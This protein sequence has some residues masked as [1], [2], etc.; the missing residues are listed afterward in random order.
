MH[1]IHPSPLQLGTKEYGW[2]NPFQS[3]T[4]NIFHTFFWCFYCWLWTSKCLSSSKLF[5]TNVKGQDQTLAVFSEKFYDFIL[6]ALQKQPP[7]V[8]WK[9][10][11]IHKK[12]PVLESVFN[13]FT[14]L[15]P[16]ALL[17]RTSSQVFSCECCDIFNNSFFIEH[18]RWLLLA[19]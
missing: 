12:K 15:Q 6:Y 19:L 1:F 2:F 10:C 14:G 9:V 7:E 18:Q 3:N 11:N 13:K 17:K 5:S 8:F 4:L 16:S